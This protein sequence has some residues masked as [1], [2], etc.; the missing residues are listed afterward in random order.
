MNKRIRTVAAAIAVSSV[1]GSSAAIAQENA[2]GFEVTPYLWASGIDADV[3]VRG[4]EG[5]VDLK[6]DDL[7]DAVDIAGALLGVA[8]Y[9]RFVVWTQLDYMSLDSNELDSDE[10]PARGRLESDVFMGT[11]AFG[12]GFGEPNGR[13]NVDVLLGA[14][15]ADIENEITLNIGRFKRARDYLDPVLIV[16][17]SFRLSERWRFN[18]TFSIGGGGDSELIWELQPQIQFQINDNL[19][20]RFGYRNLYYDIESNSQQN[21]FDGSFKGFLLGLGGTFGNRPYYLPE[22]ASASA[23]QPSNSQVRI[24]F[25]S[26]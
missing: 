25:A 5:E 4:R 14:R 15:Y 9:N 24:P 17:P 2:W 20:V 6:F 18:P 12:Y 23:P 26:M 22:R 1:L 3:A 8:Y 10:Q 19:A 13:R 11:L 7:I 21:E 16:R